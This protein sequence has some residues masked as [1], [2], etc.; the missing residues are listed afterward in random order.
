MKI[1][2]SLRYLLL[3]GIILLW[4]ACTTPSPPQST[5]HPGVRLEWKIKPGD[6][7]RYQTVMHEVDANS[8][9]IS[10][11]QLFQI[12]TDSA[13]RE[14][15]S[16]QQDFI[17]QLKEFHH[18]VRYIS[19]LYPSSHFDD[20]TEIRVTMHKDSTATE[21]AGN[22]FAQMMESMLVDKTVLRGSVYNRGGIHSFWVKTDQLNLIS[23]LFELPAKEVHPGDSWE[24]TPVHYINFDQNFVC[25]EAR[26]HNRVTLK[27]I[28][29]QGGE[30]IAVLEYDILEHVKGDYYSPFT[31]KPVA[32]HMTMTYKARSE[33]SITRG[34]WLT[35]K[36]LM[37]VTSGGIFSGKQI[38]RFE[39]QELEY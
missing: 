9:C 24:L 39:L 4:T 26:K 27:E 2:P 17:R 35:Y 25:V 19:H 12:L 3:P 10:F 30:Q 36:G 13:R 15:D 7:L 23:L 33:F 18:N 16:F 6:T 1:I 29:E 28:R 8:S 34:K 38:M 20:V 14:I 31:K 21:K 32:T 11:N 37:S 5:S 22:L